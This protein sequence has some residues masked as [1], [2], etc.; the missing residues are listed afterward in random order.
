MK[1]VGVWGR[2]YFWAW[3]C[4]LILETLKGKNSRFSGKGR[5]SEGAES[6][7][8]FFEDLPVCFRTM[9]AL[10]R[11]LGAVCCVF[12]LAADGFGQAGAVTRTYTLEEIIRLAQTDSP[13]ALI[14]KHSFRADYWNYRAYRA[15]LLPSL[16]LSASLARFNRSI[17]SLQNAET[18]VFNYVE[19]NY[20][21]NGLRLSVDQ[22]IP[23]TGG[24]VSVYTD[25][26]RLDEFS[27]HSGHT[28][29]T[30][31][32]SITY[33]QPVGGYNELKWARKI[34][35]K[36]YEES[37]RKFLEAMEDVTLRSVDLF[38]DLLLQQQS[39]GMALKNYENTRELYGTA[40]RR[41]DIGT[42]SKNELL[43]LE[44]RLLN[45]SMSI[46]EARLSLDIKRFALRSYLG[47]KEA[48]D[49]VLLPPEPMDSLR[50]DYGRVLDLSY[51]N[52]SFRI[53]QELQSIEAE[54][55]IAEARAKRGISVDLKVVFGL[56]QSG[57]DFGA[58]YR[59]LRDQ[60]ITGITLRM[61][62]MDWGLGRGRVRMAESRS[63]VIKTQ[64]EQ[65]FIDHEQEVFIAVMR[66]NSQI[67]QCELSRRADRVAQERYD[68]TLS[69]F[70][71][72][73]ISVADVNTAQ[74]EKDEA[75]RRY[76]NALRDYWY[77]YYSIR[78]LSMYDYRTRTDISAEFDRIVENE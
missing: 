30:Q 60:E 52:G 9:T 10:F 68:L 56:S 48:V 58:A 3:D 20:M 73:S 27:P 64:V 23:F 8:D 14:A 12:G 7:R 1:I 15:E 55:I 18:G 45:D 54:R 65:A 38:F 34:E 77:Y 35:P 42:L 29:Y 76:V 50:L 4:F 47:L 72:A 43:Q 57:H 75:V 31:P 13:D 49:F 33:L 40:R 24:R 67:G 22:N 44:V 5:G 6:R 61:P 53:S 25:L 16:N 21:E 62:V 11:F 28:Y 71:A 36:R 32:I 78:R 46:S 74:A 19:N 51:R 69:K 70:R 2:I 26:S 37:K 66:F 41:F 17:V 39:Y 63:E 59:S